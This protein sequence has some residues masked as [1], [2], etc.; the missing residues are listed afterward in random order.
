MNA[1]RLTR[2][3]LAAAVVSLAGCIVAPLPPH[4]VIGVAPPDD[5]V[6]VVPPPPVVGYIWIGGFWNWIGGRHVWTRG[7]WAPPRPGYRWERHRWE[8]ISGDRGD[9]GDRGERG[10]RERG[11]RWERDVR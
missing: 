7:H 2:L 3:A 8:P 5:P 11:G 10:Y 6:E 1:S 9:R 4:R